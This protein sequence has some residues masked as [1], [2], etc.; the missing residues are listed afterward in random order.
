MSLPHSKPTVHAKVSYVTYQF[1][2]NYTGCKLILEDYI[3][4]IARE[5]QPADYNSFLSASKNKLPHIKYRKLCDF[6]FS[7]VRLSLFS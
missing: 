4:Y 1:F 3:N 6:V 2:L 7:R 5:N